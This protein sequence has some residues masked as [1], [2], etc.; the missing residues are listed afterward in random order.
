[1]QT[2]GS[3]ALSPVWGGL[4][5]GFQP[6]VMDGS[7]LQRMAP[8]RPLLPPERSAASVTMGSLLPLAAQSMKVRC[9]PIVTDAAPSTHLHEG[10]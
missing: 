9:G 1:M 8:I 10:R 7:R 3:A 2:C 4:N 6:R 5:V